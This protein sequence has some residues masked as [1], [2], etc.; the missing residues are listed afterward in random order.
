MNHRGQK[1]AGNLKIKFKLK[2]PVGVKEDGNNKNAQ[3][4]EQV[5]VVP[6]NIRLWIFK[7]PLY[8]CANAIV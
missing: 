7:P 1:V 8:K 4:F 2:E 6:K 3:R 5:K